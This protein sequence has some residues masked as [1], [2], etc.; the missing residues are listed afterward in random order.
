MGHQTPDSRGTIYHHGK[1]KNSVFFT[2]TQDLA[3]V[4]GGP[5]FALRRKE[6]ANHQASLLITP[7]PHPLQPGSPASCKP[8]HPSTQPATPLLGRTSC[9]SRRIDEE[10]LYEFRF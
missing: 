2:S 10:F 4:P 7:S 6:W 5:M 8:R 1:Y 9:V 3:L